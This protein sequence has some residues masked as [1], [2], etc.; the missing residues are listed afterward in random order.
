MALASST[1]WGGP[2]KQEEPEAKDGNE[3]HQRTL[4]A[5]IKSDNIAKDLDPWTLSRI[6]ERVVEDLDID[7]TSRADWK[8]KTETA[9][10]LA[11]QVTKEK[12]FPWPKAANV[13]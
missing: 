12:Q 8:T 1:D 11:M 4:M 5:Y 13:I 10:E 2:E 7:E 3:A 6:G 9:L